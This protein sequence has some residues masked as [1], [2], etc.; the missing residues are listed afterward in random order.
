[1]SKPRSIIEIVHQGIQ[2][3]VKVDGNERRWFATKA[4]ADA[5]MDGFDNCYDNFVLRD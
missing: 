4:E 2:W 3:V 5:F 1:M